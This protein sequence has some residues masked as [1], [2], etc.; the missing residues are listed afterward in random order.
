MMSFRVFC[1]LMLLATQASA[2]P[3]C[4]IANFSAVSGQCIDLME[5]N[6]G[7]GFDMESA[8]GKCCGFGP[9]CTLVK[10]QNQYQNNAYSVLAG[11][12]MWDLAWIGASCKVISTSFGKRN[13]WTWHIDQSLVLDGFMNFD[14][15]TD[16]TT[17]KVGDCLKMGG[18]GYYGKWRSGSCNDHCNNAICAE[19]FNTDASTPSPAVRV[20]TSLPVIAPP[21]HHHHHPPPARFI[22]H[23][24][25]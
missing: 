9:N 19:N 20:V 5:R 13:A 7:V 1:A 10:I 16:A 2:D 23:K 21:L 6:D 11:Q 18:A 15:G 14:S 25:C 4:T 24:T 12:G 3:V 22:S 17:C 8:T